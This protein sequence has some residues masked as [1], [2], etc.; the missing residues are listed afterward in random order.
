MVAYSIIIPHYGIPELLRRCLASIPQRE[1]FQ[2]I[3]V[4]DR[5]P[6]FDTYRDRY[7]D[8]F[9]E[10]VTWLQTPYNGGTGLARNVGLDHASGKWLLFADADDLFSEDMAELLDTYRDAEEDILY[11]RHRCVMSDNLEEKAR[12]DRWMDGMF[13]RYFQSGD[14]RELR[15]NHCVPWAKMTRRSLVEENGLRY[16][17]VRYSNDVMFNITAASKARSVR[18]VNRELYVLT[19]RSGSLTD[20]F[21]RK[22]GELQTRAD[23]CLR[24]HKLMNDC[25]YSP[26]LTPYSYYLRRMAHQDRKLFLSNFHRIPEV[27]DSYRQAVR[28][29]ARKEDGVLRKGLLYLF[30]FY[31]YFLGKRFRKAA[32]AR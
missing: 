32:G 16:D 26:P 5:S 13:D 30:S 4:D 18:V 31:A 17:E 22:P 6:D 15:F 27:Y 12:R 11:F 8:L 20:S 21:T 3:V 10:R 7:P 19:Q 9:Q 29:M 14:D 2:I 23:V 1:D 24:A 25:G 28:E